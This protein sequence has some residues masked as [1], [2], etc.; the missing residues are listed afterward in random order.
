M[1]HLRPDSSQPPSAERVATVARRW[2][3]E[4]ASGS[5]IA[6]TIFCEPSAITG[7]SSARCASVPCLARIEP[8]IAG[9]T[10]SSS[11]GQ[12]AAANSSH[13]IANSVTPAPPPPYSSGRL[14]PRY[15]SL[16]ASV[17]NSVV[18]PPLRA[19]STKYRCP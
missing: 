15:P 13:T 7:R 16:P 6:K 4:P 17:H 8:T 14:T 3:L 18:W 2:K 10:T 12:P 19:F 9:V 1:K 11:N 5:V